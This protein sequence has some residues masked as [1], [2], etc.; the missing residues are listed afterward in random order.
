MFVLL[1]FNK[2]MFSYVFFILNVF[3][4]KNVVAYAERL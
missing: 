1:F 3:V 4:I 2:K